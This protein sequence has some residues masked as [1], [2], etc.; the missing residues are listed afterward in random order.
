MTPDEDHVVPNSLPRAHGARIIQASEQRESLRSSNRQILSVED[1]QPL[2]WLGWEEVMSQGGDLPAQFCSEIRMRD[3]DQ[4][5]G[6]L[7]Q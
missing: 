6:P 1:C 5:I 7:S 3:A 2:F 4:T